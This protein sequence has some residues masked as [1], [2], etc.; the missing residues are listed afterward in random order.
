[1]IAF[2][3]R[4]LFPVWST[5]RGSNS[6]YSTR[7]RCNASGCAR[8]G[9]WRSRRRP[10]GVTSVIVGVERCRARSGA[11]AV[12]HR[13]GL[14]QRRARRRRGGRRRRRISAVTSAGRSRTGRRGRGGR[15]ARCRRLAMTG[16]SGTVGP[17]HL[18]APR[19]ARRGSVEQSV[20][21]ETDS[22]S[23]CAEQ[24]GPSPNTSELRL[25]HRPPPRATT[26][27]RRS[28]ITSP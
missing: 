28:R 27:S 21:P 15:P 1:V 25:V 13:E 5:R 2:R 24:V 10:S 4:D 9:C 18:C 23:R 3:R 7:N 26:C 11:E 8:A 6:P 12:E 20:R 19:P 16:S 22:N 14:N 17:Q